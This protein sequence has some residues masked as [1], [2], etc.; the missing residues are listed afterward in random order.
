[1]THKWECIWRELDELSAIGQ[2]KEWIINLL[3]TRLTR[4]DDSARVICITTKAFDPQLL[5][6]TNTKSN[7]EKKR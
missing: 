4:I 1:M 3:S 5:E 7:Q 2:N 6:A